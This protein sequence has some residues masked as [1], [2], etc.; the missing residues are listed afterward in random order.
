MKRNQ[1]ICPTHPGELLRKDV[2]PKARIPK[3]K[4]ARILGISRRNLNGI[5]FA[6]K[7]VSL[8]IAVRLAK[9]FGNSPLF[10]CRMQDAWEKWQETN[11][12]NTSTLSK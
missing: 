11:D 5:L 8:D 4:V 7:P 10:W 6:R 9:L 12:V 2:I 3:S 1:H